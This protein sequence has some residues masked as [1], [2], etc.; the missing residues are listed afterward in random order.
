MRVKVAGL[1]IIAVFVSM[2]LF[3]M[4][5]E[6][7]TELLNE[8]LKMS[9]VAEFISVN[10]AMSEQYDTQALYNEVKDLPK[11]ERRQITI[12]RLK[13]FCKESQKDISM[14]LSRLEKEGSVNKVRYHWLSNVISVEATPAAI[15]KLAMRPDVAYVDHDPLVQ[16]LDDTVVSSDIIRDDD[17]EPKMTYHLEMMG[18]PE[19]WEQG[20]YG[21]GV[22]VAV[23]DSGVNYNHL[24]MI[25]RMWESEEYPY[26]GYNFADGNNNP[27]DTHSHGSHCAGIVAGTGAAGHF[28]G[29]APL[30]NIMAIKMIKDT[31]NSLESWGW[32]AIEF[33]VE[34]GAD[35]LSMSFGWTIGHKPDREVWRRVMENTLSAGVVAAVGAG[36]E[37]FYP[38]DYPIPR[39]LR[40]PGDCPP[41]WLNPEMPIR[42]GRT[43]VI[44]CGASDDLDE[45]T[46]YSSRGPG[47]WGDISP[48]FDYPYN[49]GEG[50][51]KPDVV[52][53]GEEVLSLSHEID[54][55]YLK[56]SGTSMATPNVAGVIALLLCKNP[57]LVPEQVA[58]TLES[59]AKRYVGF[60]NNES[61]SGRVNATLAVSRVVGNNAPKKPIYTYPADESV[62][63]SLTPKFKWMKNYPTDKFKI[64]LGTDN[65][66]TNVLNGYEVTDTFH[67]VE[68][69]LE[70]LTTYYWKIDAESEYGYAEGDV[71]SFKTVYPV[72]ENFE[73]GVFEYEDWY[74]TTTGS[75]SQN[76]YVSDDEAYEGSFSVRSGEMNNNASTSMSINLNVKEDGII[77]FARKISTEENSDF[78]RF[79]IGTVLQ[80]EW[81]G[82]LDWKEV[83]FPV[84]AGS[85][86]FRWTY[87]K[88]AFGTEGKDAVWIDNITFPSHPKPY[89]MYTPHT[90]VYTA[91]YDRLAIEWD[92]EENEI[93]EPQLFSLLGY[94]L[95]KGDSIEDEFELVNEEYIEDKLYEELLEEGTYYYYVT[96]VYKKYGQVNETVPSEVLSVTIY[97]AID[98]PTIE[99]QSG[100][101]NE[102]ITI[103]IES[104]E[105]VELFY[106]LDETEPNYTSIPYTEPFVLEESTTVKAIAYLDNHISSGVI[107]MKYDIIK[108][109]VDEIVE[110]VFNLDLRAFPNPFNANGISR[111]NS[112]NLTYSLPEDNT[113]VSIG[114]YNVKGQ[115]VRE[116][117]RENISKGFYQELIDLN[118]VD[119]KA[120]S[121]GIYLLILRTD[122][123]QV[124]TRKLAVV[125]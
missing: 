74:F 16:I 80:G 8:K 69:H 10:V 98:Q 111:T 15:E 96:A 81:S 54:D 117:V 28:T 6:K 114:V 1:V 55:G 48:Y 99:P 86:T 121:S 21:Q 43:A 72:S 92:I 107:T 39:N 59:T 97:P 26:Y 25:G 40:T 33:A 23:I 58:E 9:S 4:H 125:R 90:P 32:D 88:D 70:P 93:L 73:E 76:W 95:Y 113:K 31:G 108:T 61:G 104:E 75:D 82:N 49:P 115:V 53:P 71:F 83:T 105:G 100:E 51:M 91:K 35:V 2:T 124:V 65:P 116:I 13:T 34:N 24:D 123:N 122:K 94:N 56:M 5:L 112:L 109:N 27:F 12:G 101:Y 20:Y 78:L 7:G 62:A 120:V 37:G 45:L 52:S 30:A 68:S 85:R 19:V 106:T 50:L 46:V 22:L 38:G 14:L 63:I 29:V 77:T 64:F 103:T 84:E 89:V 118:S 44:T 79:Y 110:P 17:N 11:K 3:S 60:K 57:E 67:K 18:V 47:A 66:P 102:D 42:A 87:S 41:P 36:N 119:D